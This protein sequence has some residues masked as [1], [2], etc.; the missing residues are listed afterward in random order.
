[1]NSPEKP[2][3]NDTTKATILAPDGSVANIPGISLTP[4][5]A[6]LLRNYKRFLA[7]HRLREALY[8]Q[9][10][11]EGDRH[12]GCEAFVTDSKIGIRCRC[13]LRFYQ[14]ATY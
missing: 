14:G 11:W 3:V 6:E 9:D 10:C 8:C 13:R 5:E 7:R 12:D 4:E 1:M 2:L